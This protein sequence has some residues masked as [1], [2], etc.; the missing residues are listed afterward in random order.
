ML[1][2]IL[3]YLPN[4][5]RIIISNLPTKLKEQLE[6]I[7]IREDRP[8]EVLSSGNYAFVAPDSSLLRDSQQ[9]YRPT[10]EDC[11]MLLELLTNH[12][13]YS[14]EEELRRGYITCSGGH[15]VGLA[16]RTVLE[17]STVKSIRDVSSFNIRIAREIR[18]TGIKL[19]PYLLD[20]DEGRPYHTLIISPPQQGKTTLLR[21]LARS[22]SYGEWMISPHVSQP[23]NGLKVGI[24]DE[25]SEIGAS[26]HGVPRFDLGPRTD[27]MDGCPKAEGMMMMIRS[28]SPDVLVVDELGR[29]ED[30]TA[31][32][33]ALHAGIRVI[34]TAHGSSLS[35]VSKRPVLRELIEEKLFKRYVILGIRRGDE[36]TIQVLDEHGNRATTGRFYRLGKADDG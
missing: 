20:T 24:V 10:R 13:V 27:L 7:R 8:L 14:F 21:D 31:M 17:G 23:L 6:E 15:R 2:S 32:Y 28:L 26:V 1:T 19:I 25:R 36:Q 5:L 11:R 33:E 18:G 30:A 12:S 3:A 29:P 35:D 16:G 22:L 4:S 9:A 34:A